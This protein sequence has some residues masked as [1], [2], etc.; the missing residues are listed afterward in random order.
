M[1]RNPFTKWLWDA[2][3]SVLGWTLAVAFVGGGYAAFWPTINDPALQEALKSYPSALL[4]ALNYTDIASPAGYLAATVYGLLAAV[5]LIVYAVAAGTRLVAGEEEAGTLDLILAHPVGRATLALQRFA[6]LVVSLVV[7]N[8]GLELVLL[9]LVGP[10]H[11]EG[12]SLARFTAM[13]VHMVLFATFF[14]AVAFAVGAATGRRALAIGIGAGVGVWGF[15]AN[16]IITQVEGL[17]WARNLS[18]FHWLGG[19][20]PLRNGF[21]LGSLLLMLALAGALVAAGTWAFGRRDVGV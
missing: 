18:P 21:Q 3:R 1:L 14:A 17:E 5:L 15:V 8:V 9:A 12:I 10:A 7:I 11:L 4:E 19:G 13:Q 16:G 2:R 6:S 20:D